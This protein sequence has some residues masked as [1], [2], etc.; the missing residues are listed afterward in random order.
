MQPDKKEIRDGSRPGASPLQRPLQDGAVPGEW[1]LKRRVASGEP[2]FAPFVS[3]TQ[4]REDVLDACRTHKADMA[5]IDLQHSPMTDYD[6]ISFCEWSN[7]RGVPVLLRIRSPR[8]AYLIGR[9]CDFGAMAVIVPMVE[10]VEVVREAVEAFYYPPIGRRSWGP[11]QVCRAELFPGF[12]YTT[13]WN[14]NGV[15]AIQ[16]ETV[17][18]VR[19]CRELCLPGVDMV[20]FG[21]ADLSLSIA[22][23]PDCEWRTPEECIRHV[24]ESLTGSGV[25]V[26]AT[27]MPFGPM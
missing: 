24:A 1:Q 13:W 15:L 5:F 22:A 23:T 27:K 21:G 3:L 2:L 12:G 6:L 26:V 11:K 14:E 16:L 9:C 17:A 4:D 25:R 20:T 18:A 19:H 8:E 10:S 7:S